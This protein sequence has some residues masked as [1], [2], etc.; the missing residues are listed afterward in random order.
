MLGVWHPQP[1]SSP[2]PM[3]AQ[4]RFSQS[5]KKPISSSLGRKL[6]FLC[7]GFQNVPN[8]TQLQ[9]CTMAAGLTIHPWGLFFFHGVASSCHSGVSTLFSSDFGA[10]VLTKSSKQALYHNGQLILKSRGLYVVLPSVGK[11]DFFSLFQCKCHCPWKP[12]PQTTTIHTHT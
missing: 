12:L 10:R 4:N 3:T 8:R 5:V 6:T 7:T 11:C 9:L 1:W 2:P